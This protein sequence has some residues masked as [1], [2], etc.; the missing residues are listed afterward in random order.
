MYFVT[1]NTIRPQHSD[2]MVGID[3][4]TVQVGHDGEQDSDSDEGDITPNYGV[5]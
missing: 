5:L 3:H 1:F 4:P 2:V